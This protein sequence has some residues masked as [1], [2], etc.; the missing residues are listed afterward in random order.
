[1]SDFEYLCYNKD[2]FKVD[3][4]RGN[5]MVIIN[6]VLN[7]LLCFNAT[8]TQM[9]TA[10]AEKTDMS[11]DN[12]I[13]IGSI[14]T[15]IVVGVLTCLVTW[16]VTMKTIKQLKLAYSI[17]IFPILS[18]SFKQG[19]E[20][21]LTDLQINYKDKV[22]KNPCLLTLDIINTG[23]VAVK[24]PPIQI[25]CDE[26]IEIIPG[27]FEEVPHGY[28]ELWTIKKNDS[29]SC[30]ILL[31]HVNPKQIVKVRF[32]LDDF[33][34][35]KLI[36]ECPMENIQ[37]LEMVHP[38]NTTKSLTSVNS[39]R[40]ADMIIGVI[41]A[42]LIILANQWMRFLENILS[43]TGTYRYMVPQDIWLFV[44]C[45]LFLSL[46]FNINGIGRLDKFIL[47]SHRKAFLF[48]L[49]IVVFSVILLGCIIFN[50]VIVYFIPQLVAA[51][52]ASC[53]LALLIHLCLLPKNSYKVF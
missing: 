2:R 46:L 10:V 35:Q 19:K 37:L 13:G 50:F 34:N 27:Y 14:V 36:F 48:K 51:L 9:L 44:I 11:Q 6:R 47:S 22:L 52:F 31:N 8:A 1:M 39:F 41:C 5:S 32:F 43:Y 26:E 3:R 45:T 18:N 53:L 33:P 25:K 23:N 38:V 28:E 42:M 49:G 29:C 12:I 4:K 16:K 7:A 24:N 15:T 17:Q 20:L 21:A 30:K 40:K